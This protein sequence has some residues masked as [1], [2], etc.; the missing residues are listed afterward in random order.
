MSDAEQ[1]ERRQRL[2]MKREEVADF[3]AARG[4]LLGYLT[5]PQRLQDVTPGLPASRELVREVRAFVDAVQIVRDAELG[6]DFKPDGT[7]DEVSPGVTEK[8]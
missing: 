6:L 1:Y 3:H 8:Q 2:A 7:I 4:R 5:D